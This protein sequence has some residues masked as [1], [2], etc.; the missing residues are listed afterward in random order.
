MVLFLTHAHI[1][2]SFLVRPLCAG[3]EVQQPVYRE[4][5]KRLMLY[6]PAAA[7]AGQGLGA[8]SVFVDSPH[9]RTPECHAEILADPH[10]NSPDDAKERVDLQHD[11]MSVCGNDIFAKDLG[12]KTRSTCAADLRGQW[13]RT[14]K[15]QCPGP[16]PVV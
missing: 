10:T 9:A 5:G 12:M 7:E 3:L 6:L 11:V 4:C 14:V 16:E 15:E 2:L 1:Y 8:V 13:C